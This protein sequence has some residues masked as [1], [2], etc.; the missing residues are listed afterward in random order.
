MNPHA[1]RIAL[2][3][4]AVMAAF[5]IAGMVFFTLTGCRCELPPEPAFVEIRTADATFERISR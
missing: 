3:I 2:A 1:I 4:G 5:Y